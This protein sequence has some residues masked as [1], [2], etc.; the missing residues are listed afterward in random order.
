MKERGS[1]IS[2][3]YRPFSIAEV[4]FSEE[5][6]ASAE[7]GREEDVFVREASVQRARILTDASGAPTW[8][9]V[10]AAGVCH[11]V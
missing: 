1:L 9:L 6:D 7:E 4:T 11:L 10:Q 2:L 8:G 5:E 3:I